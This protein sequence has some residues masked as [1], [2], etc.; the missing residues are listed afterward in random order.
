MRA[1]VKLTWTVK[2][3]AGR[4]FVSEGCSGGGDTNGDVL[5][6]PFDSR[7]DAWKVMNGRHQAMHEF[8]RAERQ[9]IEASKSVAAKEAA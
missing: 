6:G 4:W 2:Q 9:R 7:A 5:I 3:H 1:F 8:F